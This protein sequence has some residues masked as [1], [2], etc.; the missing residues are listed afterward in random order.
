M[1]GTDHVKVQRASSVVQRGK[2][3]NLIPRVLFLPPSKKT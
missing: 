2:N 3:A 1:Q